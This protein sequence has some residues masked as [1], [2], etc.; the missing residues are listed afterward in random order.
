M[1]CWRHVRLHVNWNVTKLHESVAILYLGI[2]SKCSN[3]KISTALNKRHSK[4]L[5]CLRTSLINLTLLR[6][7]MRSSTF[8]GL[9]QSPSNPTWKKITM[10][11]FH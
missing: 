3:D 2:R 9:R 7:M 5:K 6:L 10:Q 4:E 11:H 1:T 8:N